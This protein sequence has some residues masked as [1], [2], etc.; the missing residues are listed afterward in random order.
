MKRV[1][2]PAPS[3]NVPPLMGAHQV[4]FEGEDLL[5]LRLRGEL[6]ADDIRA[7]IRVDRQLSQKNG[8]SL[9]LIDARELTVFSSAARQASF[10]EMKRHFG[11]LGSTAVFGARGTAA[12]VLKLVFR[13]LTLLASHIDDETRMFDT[14][15]EAREFLTKRRPQRRREASLR[16]AQPHG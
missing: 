4:E 15:S 6:L 2:L 12:W 10:D 5:F 7:L 13:G 16:R 8:Y 14:E 11:Y 3:L 9:V 1:T